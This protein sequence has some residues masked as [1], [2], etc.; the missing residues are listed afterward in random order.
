MSPQTDSQLDTAQ[1]NTP[2]APA[3]A[4]AYVLK[5]NTEKKR[6][7]SGAAITGE[8]LAIPLQGMCSVFLHKLS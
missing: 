7:F 1:A 6:S 2:V 3:R 5:T 4:V 8:V